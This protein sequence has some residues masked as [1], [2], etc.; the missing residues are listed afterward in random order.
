VNDTLVRRLGRTCE[1]FGPGRLPGADGRVVGAGYAFAATALLAGVLLVVTWVLLAVLDVIGRVSL[2]DLRFVVAAL[3][4]VTVSAFCAAVAVWRVLPDES[5]RYGAIGG[6]AATCLSYLV[7]T[8]FLYL[9]V[10]VLEYSTS[11][12]YAWGHVE[13]TLLVAFLGTAFTAWLTLPA[14]VAAGYVYESVRIHQRTP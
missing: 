10:L 6:F 13:T 11:Y 1:R 14:G 7:S 12:S 8:V 9:V 3:P 5:P 2:A 4:F